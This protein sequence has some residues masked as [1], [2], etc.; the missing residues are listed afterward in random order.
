MVSLVPVEKRGEKSAE[1][2]ERFC[3][4]VADAI[5][6]VEEHFGQVEQLPVVHHGNEVLAVKHLEKGRIIKLK[7]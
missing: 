3:E 7:R 6:Q 5:Q 4:T 1:T 2:Y